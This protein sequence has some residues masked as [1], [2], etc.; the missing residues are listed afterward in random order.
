MVITYSLR[1]TLLYILCFFGLTAKSFA[2]TT[3]PAD[4]SQRQSKSAEGE[5]QQEEKAQSNTNTDANSNLNSPL[6]P[7]AWFDSIASGKWTASKGILTLIHISLDSD[8]E[9]LKKSYSQLDTS[10]AQ[11]SSF[12]F[13]NAFDLSFTDR[14]NEKPAISAVDEAKKSDSESKEEEETQ[15]PPTAD[16]FEG[17]IPVDLA[18]QASDTKDKASVTTKNNAKASWKFP[19][20]LAE[21]PQLLPTWIEK[22]LSYHGVVL[23]YKKPYVLIRSNRAI[24]AKANAVIYLGTDEKIIISKKDI[25]GM[26]LAA[27]EGEPNERLFVAKIKKVKGKLPSNLIGSKVKILYPKSQKKS[28]K[29][30]KK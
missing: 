7:K 10:I 27:P 26:A 30:K 21:K 20:V 28:S 13:T 19:K 22:N 1:A 23:D 6:D 2:Q 15:Q 25:K 12:Q 24:K 17:A 14:L 4:R 16:P 5:S 9:E 8:K 29:R 11:E 3:K 18:I